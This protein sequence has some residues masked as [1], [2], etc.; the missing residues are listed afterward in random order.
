MPGIKKFS[1]M[2]LLEQVEYLVKKQLP[3]EATLRQE[4]IIINYSLRLNVTTE[5]NPFELTSK[6]Y[7]V[8]VE[9]CDNVIKVL[10]KD[11]EKVIKEET[12]RLNEIPE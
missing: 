10:I 12:I 6:Y 4:S 11:G 3:K 7:D 8:A 9:Y 2:N 5:N 1:N